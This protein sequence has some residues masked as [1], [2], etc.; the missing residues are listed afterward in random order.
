M[1]RLKRAASWATRRGAQSPISS[2]LGSEISFRLA[3]FLNAPAR[4][5]D[6]VAEEARVFEATAAIAAAAGWR[7]REARHM[8]CPHEGT[9]QRAAMATRRGHTFADFRDS[10][11]R[12][13]FQAGAVLECTCRRRR[14]ASV[15]PRPPPQHAAEGVPLAMCG[16]PTAR[17]RGQRLATRGAAYLCR[18]S[19]LVAVTLSRGWCPQ[20]HLLPSRIAAGS[21]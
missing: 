4:T 6:A 17:C 20:R 3:C 1:R 9:R 16:V 12:R 8:R 21:G 14:C 11:H 15:R 13:L 5:T 19:W 7:G 10:W 2:T 18:W